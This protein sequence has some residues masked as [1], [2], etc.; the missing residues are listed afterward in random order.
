MLNYAFD[1]DGTL[2]EAR[3]VMD[4]DFKSWFMQWMRGKN[5]YLVMAH[6]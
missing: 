6:E 2:G 5:V 3:Q 4:P 1:V